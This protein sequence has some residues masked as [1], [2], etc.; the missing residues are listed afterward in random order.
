MVSGD[1]PALAIVNV[2]GAVGTALALRMTIP[3][4]STVVGSTVRKGACDTSV[5]VKLSGKLVVYPATPLIVYNVRGAA[6]IPG[7]TFPKEALGLFE[8]VTLVKSQV[9]GNVNDAPA[10]NGPVGKLALDATK[11]EFPITRPTM[12]VI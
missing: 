9:T 2:S 7:D 4:K 1:N 3:P 5:P 6:L 12:D 11:A 10:A 8:T